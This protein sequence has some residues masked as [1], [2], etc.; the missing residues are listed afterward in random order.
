M[1]ASNLNPVPVA[2]Q[3]KKPDKYTTMF[4]TIRGE[5]IL[6]PTKEQAEIKAKELLKKF[7]PEQWWAQKVSRFKEGKDDYLIAYVIKDFSKEHD[8]S[9]LARLSE[10]QMWFGREEIG[11]PA[12]VTDTDPHSDTY[13]Q[14]IPHTLPMQLQDGKTEYF[15]VLDRIGFYNY[16][17]V[18]KENVAIFKKM[19]GITMG[20]QDT[21]YIF[22]LA[23]G[24]RTI[25]ADDEDEIWEVSCADARLEDRLLKKAR[26]QKEIASARSP[27]A[28]DKL[29]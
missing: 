15:P 19:C 4:T 27:T 28:E 22:V 5:F 12:M 18:T 17:K 29:V 13:Q 10:D 8:R 16:M 6:K 25:S 14:R 26:R 11:I 21:E 23:K 9:D 24:G 1:S 2:Q 3:I 7:K 20:D